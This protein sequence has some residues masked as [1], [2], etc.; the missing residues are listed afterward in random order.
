MEIT[1]APARWAQGA[2]GE[3]G[4]L[5]PCG[6]C[7]T[8]SSVNPSVSPS[9]PPPLSTLREAEED[10]GSKVF[11]VDRSYNDRKEDRKSNAPVSNVAV[12]SL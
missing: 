2:V 10:K 7:P 6:Q 1:E 3:G 5:R 11:R 9:S 4:Y 8:L 12:R